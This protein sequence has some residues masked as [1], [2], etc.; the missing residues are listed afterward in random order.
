M[1]K[2]IIRAYRH[3]RRDIA[4]Y[5][6][7]FDACPVDNRKNYSKIFEKALAVFGM[8]VAG[9]VFSLLAVLCC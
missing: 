8:G 7:G 2:E 3:T 5:I 6:V 9:F 1:K 4:R